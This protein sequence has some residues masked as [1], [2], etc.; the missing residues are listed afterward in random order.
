MSQLDVKS[1]TRSREHALRELK[2]TALTLLL[3][4][5]LT[6]L[7]HSQLIP[8]EALVIDLDAGTT[9]RG[10]LFKVN[11]STGTRTLV[12][13]FGDAGQGPLGIEPFGL[14]IDGAGNVLVVD[15]SA[16]TNSAGGLFRV[17]PSTGART[18]VSD[19]GDA[20]QGPRGSDPVGLAI[21]GV[22]AACWSWMNLW[23]PV[24]PGGYS[25]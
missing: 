19:F 11:P 24:P 9:E 16:G 25:E 1:R 6:P 3:I 21:E 14:A 2:T 13:D 10:A 8:G 4:A 23:E 22:R 5:L 18:L 20:A 7:A 15:G 12:S 17:N